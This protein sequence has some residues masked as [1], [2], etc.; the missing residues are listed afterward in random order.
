MANYNRFRRR[1]PAISAFF[2]FSS[3]YFGAIISI[4]CVL[5]H[6]RLDDGNDR[7]FFFLYCGAMVDGFAIL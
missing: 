7:T 2:G 5:M 6:L 3:Q 4:M 1:N